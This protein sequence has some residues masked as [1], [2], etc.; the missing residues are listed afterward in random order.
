LER[1]KDKIDLCP[2]GFVIKLI[3]KSDI[4]P[5]EDIGEEQNSKSIDLTLFNSYKYN[6][7]IIKT[8]VIF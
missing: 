8:A 6:I 5:R 4:M 2:T 1:N 7:H 3:I